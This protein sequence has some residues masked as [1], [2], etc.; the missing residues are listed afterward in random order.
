MEDAS[1]EELGRWSFEDEECKC[2][3]EEKKFSA[4]KELERRSCEVKQ[5]CRGDL[6]TRYPIIEPIQEAAKAMT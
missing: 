5:G 1:Y 2:I 3:K 4:R 6:S